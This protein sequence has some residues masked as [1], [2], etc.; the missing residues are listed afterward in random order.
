[1]A[2]AIEGERFLITGWVVCRYSTCVVHARC[3]YRPSVSKF[4][5]SYPLLF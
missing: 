2:L 1:M 3:I 4:S 5:K